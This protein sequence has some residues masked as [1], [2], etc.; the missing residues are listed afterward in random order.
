MLAFP[1]L[2]FAEADGKGKAFFS[3]S[4]SYISF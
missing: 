4:F 2:P 1:R 3:S